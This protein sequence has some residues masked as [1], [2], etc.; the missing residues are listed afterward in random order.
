MKADGGEQMLRPHLA[1]AALMIAAATAIP[2]HAQQP[3]SPQDLS[4]ATPRQAICGKTFQQADINND[5][6]L[7]NAD[8]VKLDQH[9]DFI[10]RADT[11][12]D[13]IVT[14]AEF[15]ASCTKNL[16]HKAERH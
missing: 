14:V 8:F 13:G 1:V 15:N 10:D 6:V 7:T 5:G 11:N 4:S 12:S 3:A 16:L 9:T 2:T